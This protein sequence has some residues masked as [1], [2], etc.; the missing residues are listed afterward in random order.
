MG[1]R[2]TSRGRAAL[3]VIAATS[4]SESIETVPH[5]QC[6]DKFHNIPAV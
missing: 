2:E 5:E 1:M 4:L 3:L 6:V